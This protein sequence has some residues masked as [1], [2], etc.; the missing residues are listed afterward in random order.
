[1][2]TSRSPDNK[3]ASVIAS[4]EAVGMASE[5]SAF[6]KRVVSSCDPV[7]FCRARTLLW[8]CG[9]LCEFA[10]G[11]G[12]EATPEIL[13]SQ[14]VIERFVATGMP[15]LS[16]STRRSVRTNLRFVARHVVPGG[17]RPATM[18]R[19]ALPVPYLKSEIA[20]MFLLAEHQAPKKRRM[21]LQGLLC[22]GLGAGLS[23]SDLRHVTGRHMKAHRG[24]VVVLVEGR[25]Q[26]LVPVLERY[27]GRLV[28]SA[29][30]AGKNYVTGGVTPER[31][32]LTARLVKNI[33]GGDDVVH[34]DPSR[35]RITWLVEMSE[36]IG[37]K[38]LLV[39]AG[40]TSS[41][42]LGAI[43]AHCCDIEIDEALELL[44]GER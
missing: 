35:L 43:A 32:N 37:L 15:E 38:A 42:R 31:R 22:L 13:L 12:L 27:S 5:A 2:R 29:R 11:I 44:G 28:E 10:I 21:R 30:F 4:Y 23:G 39:A 34:I 19:S 17:A 3:I 6:A 33:A 9:R 20:S 1:M 8:S 26:R 40:I 7:G 14:A 18:A 36:R 25:R 41:G 24:G 16:E